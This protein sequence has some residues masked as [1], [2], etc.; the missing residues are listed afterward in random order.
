L[1]L[2]SFAKFTPCEKL[3]PKD[4]ASW[5]DDVKKDTDS[6]IDED[7]PWED[8]TGTIIGVDDWLTVITGPVADNTWSERLGKRTV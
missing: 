8:T 4:I 6:D 7:S 1:I 3:R 2:T 5:T